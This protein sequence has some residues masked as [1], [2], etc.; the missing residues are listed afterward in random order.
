MRDCELVAGLESKDEGEEIES[1]QSTEAANSLRKGLV[2]VFT[3]N[4]F[5][6]SIDFRAGTEALCGR[7]A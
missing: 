5:G 4:H 3:V 7:G 1:Q 6:L 2:E